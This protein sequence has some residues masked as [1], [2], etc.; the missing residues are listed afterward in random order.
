[1]Y[2]PT[3]A[4]LLRSSPELPDLDLQRLPEFFTDTYATIVSERLR[5]RTEG[6]SVDVPTI[7]RIANTY[8]AYAALF[9]DRSDRRAAAFIA[10][11]AHHLIQL[12]RSTEENAPATELTR[13]YITPDIS[14]LLLFLASGYPADAAQM[15]RQLNVHN[16]ESPAACLGNALGALAAGRIQ[17]V[18]ETRV[19]ADLSRTDLIEAATDEL[20]RL[21]LRGL[22]LMAGRILGTPSVQAI[23]E[24]PVAIFRAVQK[25]A[26]ADV[27][28]VGRNALSIFAGPHQLASLLVQVGGV[29]LER[30]VT[31]LPPPASIPEE[32]W[33]EFLVHT[34]KQRPFLWENHL[35]AIAKGYLDVGT[36]AVVSFPTGSGKSTLAEL[37]IA[38]A[39]LRDHQVVFI[40][41]THAL[42][43]QVRSDLKRAFP[44]A[45]VRE[46]L[47]AD[48]AYSEVEVGD[49]P[50][51]AVMT[52]ERTL[53]LLTTVPEAF[54]NVGL[55]VLDEC[56]LLHPSN[57]VT[58]RRS[59]DAMLCFLRVT[60]IATDAD[61]LMMSAMMGNEGVI[62]EWIEGSHKSALYP[63]ET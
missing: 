50:D 36:S 46:S 29:L 14:A 11:T 2:D 3:T 4:A 22:Q 16:D 7:R 8:E 49:L 56:H 57:G 61:V 6:S 10:G 38:T 63:F 58:D 26:V 52:P 54:T 44:D 60:D 9:P 33:K 31:N 15:A 59:L 48:G 35:E 37:K 39:L 62:S 12:A 40:V 19:A 51:I 27:E 47:V 20:W 32:G 43:G 28:G 41:P 1:M 45:L 42:V 30:R 34:A 21:L 55:I 24:D 25:L 13:D 5:L 53:S 23:S 17:Q 18:L